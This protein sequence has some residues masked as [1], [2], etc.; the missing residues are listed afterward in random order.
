MDL[1]PEKNE[2]LAKHRLRSRGQAFVE[3]KTPDHAL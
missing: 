2:A 1:L 3:K